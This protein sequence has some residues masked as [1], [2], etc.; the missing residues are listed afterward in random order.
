MIVAVSLNWGSISGCLCNR[1]PVIVLGSTLGL[2]F[3][4]EALM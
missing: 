3:F 4:L 1:S 2:V